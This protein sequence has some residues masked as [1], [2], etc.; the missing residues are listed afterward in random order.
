M[1]TTLILMTL[2]IVSCLAVV[3]VLVV[4]L[5]ILPKL[6]STMKENTTTLKN[7]NSA[8]GSNSVEG[9]KERMSPLAHL[10]LGQVGQS[11]NQARKEMSIEPV[12]LAWMNRVNRVITDPKMKKNDK[13]TYE[14]SKS[15]TGT[16]SVIV[17]DDALI[18]VDNVP[19][20][21]I[22]ES[23]ELGDATTPNGENSESINKSI[24]LPNAAVPT[25]N[26]GTSESQIPDT[27][28]PVGVSENVS[29]GNINATDSAVNESF[30]SRFNI[31]RGSVF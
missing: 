4:A 6:N 10:K 18:D 16:G 20:P 23:S 7:I 17:P 29:I 27:I 1:D 3:A 22:S 11:I 19:T 21:S 30:R 26:L 15:E 5:A 25:G 8:L 12:A 9:F 24:D 31:S 28:R 13:T 2:Q 14:S